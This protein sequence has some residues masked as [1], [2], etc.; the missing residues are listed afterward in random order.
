MKN[1]EK[2]QQI[3]YKRASKEMRI[4]INIVK[5]VNQRIFEK[6][7][8]IKFIVED[9]TNKLHIDFA[10]VIANTQSLTIKIQKLRE[11]DF[12][13]NNSAKLFVINQIEKLKRTMRKFC[14]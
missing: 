11:E 14:I 9:I 4:I 12:F 7:H 5:V 8:V 3:Y 6:A 10:N 1:I 13:N 2:S